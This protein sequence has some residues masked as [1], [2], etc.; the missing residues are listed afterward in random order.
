MSMSQ[1]D[2]D[3]LPWDWRDAVALMLLGLLTVVALWWYLDRAPHPYS[4]T[5]MHLYRAFELDRSIQQR[6]FYPRLGL[7]FNFT[8][9]GPLLQYR[10]PLVH[11]VLVAFHWAGLPWVAAAKATATLELLLAASGMYLYGRW[12]FKARHAALAAAAAYLLA[13]Y[14]QLDIQERG[15]IS[16]AMALALLPW[17]FWAIHRT[18]ADEGPIWPWLAALFSALLMLAHNIVAFYA[19]PV[20][21][22]YMALLIWRNRDFGRLPAV[23]GA[24]ALG[25]A[26]SAF[27]WVP[28][29]FERNAAQIEANM[30]HVSIA[31]RLAP[32]SEWIQRGLVF[33]YWGATRHRPASWQALILV[34]AFAA[35]ILR[36]TRLRS[37]ML[38][39]AGIAAISILLQLDASLPVWQAVPP[40]RFLQ[41]PFRLMGMAAFCIALLVGYLIVSLPGLSESARW[42]FTGAF[43]AFLLYS[44]TQRL[45]PQF[46]P[47]TNQIAEDEI[48]LE[49]LNERGRS[50]FTIFEDFL[51]SAVRIPPS[52]LATSRSTPDPSLSPLS[53]APE[54]T[55]VT[56][57]PFR[58]DLQVRAEEPF[59]LRLHRF[60]FPG[61]QAIANG[62]DLPTG[63]SGNHGV[64]T[65]EFPAGDYAAIIG[66][67]NT[68]VR[69]L[70]SIVSVVSLAL[71]IV[72]GIAIRRARPVL[73]AAAI[74]FS[75]FLIL[76]VVRY[77]VGQPPR[78]PVSVAANFEDEIRLLG[79]NVPKS[80]WR[81]GEDLPLRL[82]WLAQRTP[83]EDYKVFVHLIVPDD[84]GR[85]AQADGFPLSGYGPTSRWEPG[86]IVVDE[87][88]MHLDESIPPGAYS[89][90][91]GLYHPETVQNLRV[92]GASQVLPGDRVVLGQIDVA[93]R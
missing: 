28:A 81:P 10:P 80:T 47:N 87:H 17:L 55:V 71:W 48:S 54:I 1:P 23:L 41:F 66:F 79:Y 50:Y 67:G 4:D 18:M 89:I 82:Y 49:G 61:W 73:V 9:A 11:Y 32:L 53:S 56:E 24:L 7:D 29:F 92:H 52:E 85:A 38:I 19:F 16:E 36:P 86:E 2:R 46:N 31:A 78:H 59:T 44:S 13:P 88:L 30:L 25:L 20:L 91:V 76:L 70:A 40:A 74:V 12:L 26:I 83:A 42:L 15:A 51:P 62:A 90:V 93:A 58:L 8:Y 22:L 43:I 6:V 57:R 39:L 60:F 65:A 33:D 63:P 69:S 64:V 77:G 35:L 84:S 34:S 5:T 75:V 14:V 21:L 45:A 3:V 27:Y 72:A 68:P 37:A